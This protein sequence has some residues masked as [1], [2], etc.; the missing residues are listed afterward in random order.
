LGGPT[1]SGKTHAALER[2][3]QVR[4]GVYLAP[5]RLLALEVYERLRDQGVPVSLVTGEERIVDPCATHL[6]CTVEMLPLHGIFDVAVIDEIQMLVDPA[7]GWAWTQALLGVAAHEVLL[8]G[9]LEAQDAVTQV[10]G[11]TGESLVVHR[12]ERK[13]PLRVLD[14][15]LRMSDL[16]PGDCV[17]AFTRKD[18]LELTELI[19]NKTGLQTATIYG[20]LSPEVRRMQARLFHEGQADVLV[21]TDAI[22]MGLNLPIRRVVFSSV[23]KFDGQQQ[24]RLRVSETLQIAG[25]AGRYGLH[26]E[27]LVGAFNTADLGFL[28]RTLPR[29]GEP[30]PC[31]VTVMPSWSHVEQYLALKDDAD[32][33]QALTFFAQLAPGKVTT[34]SPA[35]AGM[36]DKAH[37]A[38]ALGLGHKHCYDWAC[39][40][41]EFEE[42]IFQESLYAFAKKGGVKRIPHPQ[43]FLR[44]KRPDPADLQV[45]EVI[46]KELTFLAWYAQKFESNNTDLIEQIAQRRKLCSD[47]IHRVLKGSKKRKRFE[48]LW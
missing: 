16:Q 19:Q 1:N 29:E 45:A 27:G 24:R 43:D 48:D 10:L 4:S 46:S 35:V 31:P 8:C 20:A 30:V 38:K 36:I 22:G 23:E 12:F 2:L 9:A 47:F 40:P 25:R 15:P 13:N 6:C 5:L 42:S 7:R 14:R 37:L 32:V 28:K 18:V 3:R 26:D 39:A 41:A 11:L 33:A 44:L 34:V 21:A 17:V